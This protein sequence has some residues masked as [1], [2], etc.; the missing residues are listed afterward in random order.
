M[1][2]TGQADEAGRAARATRRRTA[3]AR[4]NVDTG[5]AVLDHLLALLAAVRLVRP[6]RSRSR[7]ATPRPR[8]PPRAARW[9]QA[10]A[11]RAR[12][13]RARGH[14]LGGGSRGRGPRARRAR[15]VGRAA[16]VSN[17]DLT[18]ARVGGPRHA[19]SSRTFLHELAEGAGL[20]LHVR[21]IEGDGHAARARGD[22]QGARRRARAEL[23]PA[24]EGGAD[25]D[26]EVVRTEAAPG[27]FQGAPYSQAIL[28][29]GLRL[30]LRAARAA[31]RPRARSSARRS[32]SRPSRCSRTC[33]AILEAAGSG[34]DR[35]VK[36]TVFLADLDDFPG[37][38][39]VYAK[40]V[41]DSRRPARR[42]RSQPCPQARRSKS[43][44]SRPRK[45]R[46]AERFTEGEAAAELVGAAAAEGAPRAA[47]RRC[48]RRRWRRGRRRRWRRWRRGLWSRRRCLGACRCG[49]SR[50]CVSAS[51]TGGNRA[52]VAGTAR[53]E[54]CSMT[55]A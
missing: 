1:A 4:R 33:G 55:H 16:V 36:T 19:T 39:A 47:E 43:K 17:V 37:M 27:P 5:A 21:L 24:S 30:R 48:L 32:R 2:R 52:Q 3:A 38:N 18:D 50:N 6:R 15:G 45:R 14:R 26:K 8:S 46:A 31:A 35:L 11:E 29:G 41:G 51:R 9:A 53:R 28:A 12:A 49:R 20:T 25:G 44:P 40:H 10:L 23:P 22:L 7:R 54:P 34:L 42:S 13:P